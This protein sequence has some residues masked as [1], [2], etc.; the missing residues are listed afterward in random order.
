MLIGVTYKQLSSKPILQTNEGSRI[1]NKHL[2]ILFWIY[3]N[4]ISKPQKSA[5][6]GT[7]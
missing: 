3:I 6:F 1:H 4:I 7:Y 2:L 5:N